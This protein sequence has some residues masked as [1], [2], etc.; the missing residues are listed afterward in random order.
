MF[1]ITNAEAVL[2]RGEAPTVSLV[3][4]VS[5][6]ERWSVTA[7]PVWEDSGALIS[8]LPQLDL[9]PCGGGGGGAD[10]CAGVP[11]PAPL[12]L[13]SAPA[14]LDS[15]VWAAH[16][17]FLLAEA[18]GLWDVVPGGR[19]GTPPLREVSIGELL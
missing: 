16:P 10:P 18:N 11:A 1:N 8:W 14:S 9:F 2:A 12:P 5:F 15:R 19:D 4:P 7:E 13:P 3:G 17:P 6:V